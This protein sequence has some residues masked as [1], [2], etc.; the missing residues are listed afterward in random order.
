MAFTLSRAPG[1]DRTPPRAGGSR[2]ARSQGTAAP[3][4]TDAVPSTLRPQ[5]HPGSQPDAARLGNP[6]YVWGRGQ[7]RRLAIIE[8]HARLDGRRVLDLGCG[9]GEYV[10]AFSRRGALA[11]GSDIELP[12]LREARTRGAT[13]VLAAAGEALPFRDGALDVIVLNE[14]IEHV[15]DDRQ[16]IREVARV[17]APGG[18]C[19]IFAPNRLFPFETHG[20][21]LP[22]L[23]TRHRGSEAGP[24]FVF[25]NIPLVNWLPRGLRDRLVPHA[26]VYTQSDLDDVVRGSGLL[27]L[28]RDYVFPGFDNI[29]G[30]LG[31]A[32]RVLRTAMHAVEDSPARRFGISHVYV[33]RK[34]DATS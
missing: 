16:T 9:V 11:L 29:A 26:R 14:V 13:T 4:P 15:R 22:R 34:Q 12:R 30:R 24:R 1:Y 31:L 6:S 32:G 28:A 2:I 17:L 7:D 19:I 33:L 18:T 10:R 3:P 8:R 23:Q 20:I 21:Y 25:G 5:A 27:I